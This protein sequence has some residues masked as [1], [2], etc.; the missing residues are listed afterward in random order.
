MFIT[1]AAFV[2]VPP[3]RERWQ[4]TGLCGLMPLV[5]DTD[6]NPHLRKAQ[7]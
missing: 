5:V 7:P 3:S 2:T 4:L 6:K 1:F